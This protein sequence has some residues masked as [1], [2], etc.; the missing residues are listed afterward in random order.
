MSN[1]NLDSHL[2][3]ISAGLCTFILTMGVTWKSQVDA[4]LSR[5]QREYVTQIQLTET[6]RQLEKSIQSTVENM[7][8]TRATEAA[9][10]TGWLKRIESHQAE[11]TADIKELIKDQRGVVR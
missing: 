11:Q 3:K 9:A 7:D 8:K 10:F 4:D 5:I 1:S 2:S 6:L